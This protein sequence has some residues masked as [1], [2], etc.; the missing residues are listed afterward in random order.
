MTADQDFID[1]YD[2]DGLLNRTARFQNALDPV[3]YLPGGP[4]VRERV[5]GDPRLDEAK[6]LMLVEDAIKALPDWP[7]RQFGR[8]HFVHEEDGRIQNDEAAESAAWDAI[9]DAVVKMRF[10]E[11]IDAHSGAQR[12]LTAL[13]PEKNVSAS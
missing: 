4:L 9:I 8:L 2:R 13:C 5:E 12:Y 11:M 7:Y 1:C 6:K 3:P 10:R